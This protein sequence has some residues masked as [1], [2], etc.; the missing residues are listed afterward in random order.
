M[1]KTKLWILLLLV[2]IVAGCS[3][4]DD[5]PQ[6]E[7]RKSTPFQMMVVFAPGQLGDIGYADAVMK[8]MSLLN[9]IEHSKGADSLSVRFIASNNNE[10]A[11]VSL[12]AWA[13]DAKDQFYGDEYERR[14]LVLT[15]PYMISWL[16]DITASLRP[17]DEVLLLK[18]NEDDVKA[19]ASQYGLGNRLHGLN[20]S[21]TASIR[22]F[23]RYMNHY[24]SY[25]NE[26]GENFNL[27][28][29]PMYRLYDPQNT[30]YRDSIAETLADELGNSTK[31]TTTALSSE[32][33]DGVYNIQYNTSAIELAYSTAAIVSEM[34]KIVG[35][36]FAIVDLGAANTGWDYYLLGHSQETNFI[37]LMLD[38]QENKGVSR[39]Y[40]NRMFDMALASWGREWI[41]SNVGTMSQQT[42]IS[43]ELGCVDNIPVIDY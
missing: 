13:A 25:M 37:T 43:S 29:A 11:R 6:P 2:A 3:K 8:G 33:G 4:D 15:E 9:T 7:S 20:I 32:A 14:L 40:I 19:A 41:H 21:A 23:C 27:N 34:S 26:A 31:I 1:S 36:S 39:F 16:E 28:R 35:V 22:K 18:V 30:I 12:K 42:T 38:A 10:E 5:S 24:I 17:V